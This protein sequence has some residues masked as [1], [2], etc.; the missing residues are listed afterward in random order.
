MLTAGKFA[1]TDY[2][3]QNS[4]AGDPRTAF[5]NWNAYGNGS[6][7]LTMDKVGWTWGAMADLNQKNWA[8]R[9]GYFLVP[10][11]SNTNNFD[12]N[13]PQ[14]GEYV[15]ELE[16]RYAM[17]S[18]PG[19]LRFFGWVNR[20]IMGSYNDA[21]ALPL[22]SPNYPNITLTRQVRTN[23]GGVVNLEQAIND[24]F[25]VFS[26]ASW[27]PGQ[28]E[29]IG[30]TDVSNSRSVGAVLKGTS[31]G[32]PNDRIGLAGVTQ[33]LSDAA[34]TYFAAGGIGILIGDGALNYRRENVIEAYYA[35]SLNRFATLT[36]D[37]QFFQN[38]AYNAD[39]G[40]VSVYSTRLHAEF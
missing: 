30:W 1:V 26:R 32:R 25:G 9:V 40:P 16:L 34:K 27:S 21:V 8:F 20:A 28:D 3:G 33:G 36:L 11:A 23:W 29:I 17:A 15:A 31:W 13:I 22:A 19:K 7:D 35:Y 39:R 14:R 24:D 10:V 38:P 18:Q 12:T 5:L 4:Y 37:Y 2:F 6:Y